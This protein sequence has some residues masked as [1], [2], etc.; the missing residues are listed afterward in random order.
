[1]QL[2]AH[3]QKILDDMEKEF[4]EMTGKKATHIF[5]DTK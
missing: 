4:E 2:S 1:M 3:D 5:I